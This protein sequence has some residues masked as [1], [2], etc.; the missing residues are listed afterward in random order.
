MVDVDVEN[1]DAFMPLAQMC[2]R[3]RA[4]VEEA[5]AAGHVTVGVMAGRT[6]ERVASVLAIENK[7]GCR[8][9]HIRCRAC[10]SESAG[11][12]RTTGIGRVPAE[13]PDDMGRIG[14]A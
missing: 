14:R 2:R 1:D 6:A 13:S 5:E 10:R 9:R 11:T 12:D 8:R 4:V 3:D 7:L